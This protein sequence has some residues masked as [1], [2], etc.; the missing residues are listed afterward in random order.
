MGTPQAAATHFC[1]C[2]SNS[3]FQSLTHPIP[4]WCLASTFSSCSTFHHLCLN[5]C[6]A[7]H[8]YMPS[9][10]SPSRSILPTSRPLFLALSGVAPLH[11]G[12]K[13]KQSSW[14]LHLCLPLPSLH[15]CQVNPQNMCF[16][17]LS[18]GSISIPD[19]RLSRRLPSGP[20]SNSMLTTSSVSLSV[21]QHRKSEL[22][23]FG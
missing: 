23:Y 5:N 14:L 7:F 21:S 4:S 17:C 12:K 13:K 6:T 2:K 9:S 20:P 16:I 10:V 15:S 3:I 18:S 19:L 1:T 8:L 22:F 11:S